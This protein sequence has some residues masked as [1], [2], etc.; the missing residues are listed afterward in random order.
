MDQHGRLPWPA[1]DDLS[2]DAERLYDAIAR[3]PRATG[4]QYFRLTDDAG[5]LEGPF[6]AMVV[7]PGV[8]DAIQS[9]GAAIRFQSSLSPRTREIAILCVAAAAR[10]DFEWYAHE[11]I[12]RAAGLDEDDLAGIRDLAATPDP[13]PLSAIVK[14]VATSLAT[15]REIDEQDYAEAERLLGTVGL[16]ELVTLVGYYLMLDLSMRAF[17][18]PLPRGVDAPFGGTSRDGN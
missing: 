16:V 18:T 10:S 7:A 3:G 17:R 4:P 13:D 11:G 5:R 9:L 2:G 6:N 14:V 12:G 1:P 8:G 15:R